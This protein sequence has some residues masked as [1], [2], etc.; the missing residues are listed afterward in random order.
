MCCV[1]PA[2]ARSSDFAIDKP[3]G[4]ACPNLGTDFRCG[5]H[6]SLRDK[7]F[8]GCTVF[9]CFGAGQQI[10]RSTYAGRDWQ[11]DPAGAGQMF[12]AFGVMRHLHELLYYLTESL[13]VPRARRLHAEVAA[14]RDGI[15]ALTDGSPDELLALDVAPLRTGVGDLLSRVSDLARSPAGGRKP[16]GPKRDRRGADLVG[17]VLTGTNFRGATL[18]GAY[19]IGADLTDAD[20]RDT[21]LLGAD[22]RGADLSGANLTGALF[23]L[24][25]QL[26]SARGDARTVLPPSRTQPTHWPADARL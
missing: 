11:A 7:G 19:L 9:D 4:R 10:S 25:S 22:L 21:D 18:R 26:N 8:A 2:F 16:S 23:L 6:S 15:L 20:L 14:A 12:A 24:Q 17:A 3:A 13:E 1:A 5:I